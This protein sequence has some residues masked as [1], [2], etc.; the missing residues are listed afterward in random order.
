MELPPVELLRALRHRNHGPARRGFTRCQLKITF[1][2]SE[3]PGVETGEEWQALFAA[4]DKLRLRRGNK[5]T[6]WASGDRLVGR[7]RDGETVTNVAAPASISDAVAALRDAL[8]ALT[9]SP[10]WRVLDA[11]PSGEGV[12]VESSSQGGITLEVPRGGDR[13]GSWI[14]ELEPGSP[15]AS[16]IRNSTGGAD[17]IEVLEVLFTGVSHPPR[18]VQVPGVGELQLEFATGGVE[19]L[20]GAFTP[21]TLG[22]ASGADQPDGPGAATAPPGLPSG[23]LPGGGRGQIGAPN[24]PQTPYTDMEPELWLLAVEDPGDWPS[25]RETWK[26]EFNFL[27]QLHD[28]QLAG[29]PELFVEDGEALLGITFRPDPAYQGKPVNDLPGK[30]IR[31]RGGGEM[32][33]V[34][35]GPG[36]FKRMAQEA[37]AALRATIQEQ[38]LTPRGPVRILPLVDF[39]AG[40]P[41]AAQVETIRIRAEVSVKRR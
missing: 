38:G 19:F 24:R 25:R 6:W 5:T 11:S 40:E 20:D 30:D 32:L 14:Y 12:T 28:Q 27:Y 15:V 41:T 4:P 13:P 16:R 17:P 9:L 37:E 23:I 36:P 39:A 7:R 35:R 10:L 8:D 1:R 21:P 33:V 26:S 18:R 34:F 22:A 2:S 3:I 29:L 31:V